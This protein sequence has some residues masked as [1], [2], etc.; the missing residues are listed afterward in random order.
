MR[1]VPLDELPHPCGYLPDRNATYEAYLVL[2]ASLQEREYL[3]AAGYRSFGKY[4]FRPKCIGCHQCVPLRV[5]VAR[6]TPTKSQR[7]TWRRCQQIDVSV[8]TPRYTLEKWEI[9]QD[10]LKR[11]DRKTPSTPE[12]FAFSFYD[13]TIPAVEF[14]YYLNGQLIAVGIVGV[15][16]HALSSVYFTYR[17]EHAKLSLGT[18]SVMAEIDYARRH[19]KTH[20]YLGYYVRPNHFMSYKARYCPN[21][22]LTSHAQWIPFYDEIGNLLEAES[23]TFVPFPCITSSSED[24]NA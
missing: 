1:I 10:H 7:R 11:F 6:F 21:E 12:D 19:G 22:I 23:P 5:P 18:F 24:A 2:E 13:T 15:T 4:Y 16:P 9:Y 3:L 17:L 8:D 14:C 20:L